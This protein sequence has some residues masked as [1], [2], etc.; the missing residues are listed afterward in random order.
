MHLIYVC[1][2]GTADTSRLR[3]IMCLVLLKYL[4]IFYKRN[5]GHCQ[6][7]FFYTFSN[8]C[9]LSKYEIILLSQNVWPLYESF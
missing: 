1:I 4:G 3:V 7:H 8:N 2:Q 6:T 5:F 9:L